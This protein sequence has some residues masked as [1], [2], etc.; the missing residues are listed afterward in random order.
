MPKQTI[1][2]VSYDEVQV[3]VT[4]G[5]ETSVI[6]VLTPWRFVSRSAFDSHLNIMMT[7]WSRVPAK[8]FRLCRGDT[9]GIMI[10]HL[11]NPTTDF[12][13]LEPELVPRGWTRSF[14]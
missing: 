3:H 2:L 1:S 14:Q 11:V 8:S 5:D 10:I 12:E 13:I 4:R 9:D 7:A 6:G